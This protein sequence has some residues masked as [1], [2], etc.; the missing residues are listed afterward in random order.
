[1]AING[2]SEVFI[3]IRFS[4]S[5]YILGIFNKLLGRFWSFFACSFCLAWEKM[6]SSF[7]PKIV[8]GFF[9]RGRGSISKLPI[10]LF[11]VRFFWNL[12]QCFLLLLQGDS[13]G[14]KPKYQR[15][16]PIFIFT[17]RSQNSL[18][19]IARFLWLEHCFMIP[20]QGDWIELKLKLVCFFSHGRGGGGAIKNI[21]LSTVRSL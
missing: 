5:Q 10:I 20:F 3:A 9:R 17:G 16:D 12:K 18:F 19:F 4:I 7:G 6:I 8:R 13:I 14:L 11:I 1:M 21:F 2:L 15:D